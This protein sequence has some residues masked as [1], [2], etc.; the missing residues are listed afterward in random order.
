MAEKISR[1]HP[2]TLTTGWIQ[3]EKSEKAAR[4]QKMRFLR[5][6]LRYLSQVTSVGC[7]AFFRWVGAARKV[8]STGFGK[9]NF[10]LFP[11]RSIGGGIQDQGYSARLYVQD[12]VER[13]TGCL[14]IFCESSTY[15]NCESE[16]TVCSSF[17]GYKKRWQEGYT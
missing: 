11:W 5:C 1:A 2:D 8:L 4:D 6:I 13:F 10:V 15:Q 3:R 12:L 7:Y 14:H 17:T 9:A 16:G